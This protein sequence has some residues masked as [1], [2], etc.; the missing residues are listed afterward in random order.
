M[1]PKIS[2][3]IPAYEDG[4]RLEGLLRSIEE[5]TEKDYQ[6]IISDDSESDDCKK[7][8]RKFSNRMALTYLPHKRGKTAAANWN[9]LLRYAPGKI[10]KFMHQDDWFAEPE[11]LKKMVDLLEESGCSFAFSGW[12]LVNA[13]NYVY[14][15]ISPEQERNL[16]E[17][18]D[19]LF[20]GNC[21]GA[22]SDTI[23]YKNEVLF[24]EE[25]RWAVDIDFY[26]QYLHCRPGFALT[27]EPL[28]CI[29]QHDGQ[30]TKQVQND[31][32]INLREFEKIFQKYSL[33]N[34]TMFCEYMLK[35][36]MRRQKYITMKDLQGCRTNK[37]ISL[38]F[39]ERINY[40]KSSMKK[41]ILKIFHGK[42]E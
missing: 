38:W 23:F 36:R 22:P 9:N 6:V 28:V 40:Y 1:I 12:K 34:V 39:R 3:L 4:K 33:D 30:V 7:V 11:S 35:I 24:D 25:M 19:N 42:I 13:S 41:R 21:I 18:I 16:R 17:N 27:R 14:G 26:L 8:A 20:L 10:I 29:E 2:I 5:Q 15:F 32:A 37:V 31:D